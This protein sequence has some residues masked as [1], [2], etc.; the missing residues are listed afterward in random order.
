[1]PRAGNKAE[2]LFG[3]E[4]W[5]AGDAAMGSEMDAGFSHE[6]NFVTVLTVIVILVVVFFTFRSIISSTVLVAMIQASVF[7]TTAFVCLQGYQVNYIALIL[8]QCIL[9]GAT[10]DYGILLFDHYKDVRRHMDKMEAVAE[11][12][13]L[14]IRTIL[15]SSLIL[16]GTCLTVSV[17]MTQEIISQTCMIL[18]Y[19]AIC[20]V[21]LVIFILPA[22]LVLLDRNLW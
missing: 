2:E 15:T 10:I 17:L 14:S 4:T 5:L 21:I 13:N 7:I 9:M 12:M 3:Q 19:G 11:A 16:I 22:I 6:L 18:A 20:S 1:M 8:V